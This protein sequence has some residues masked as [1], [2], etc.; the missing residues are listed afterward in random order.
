MPALTRTATGT[1]AR[2]AGPDPDQL[3]EA[4]AHF[5][6]GVV[7]VT[8]RSETRTPH[9]FTASSFCAVSLEPP[10]VSVCLARAARCHPA[11]GGGDRF[12]VNMLR[13]GHVELARRFARST[14]DK[15]EDGSFR[16]TQQAG[17]L[18]FSRTSG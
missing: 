9:G 2:G 12:T 14:G 6:S 15:F 1:V 13:P 4:L 3:R 11:F 10:L 7:I 16:C 18:H 8:T 5:P 17:E